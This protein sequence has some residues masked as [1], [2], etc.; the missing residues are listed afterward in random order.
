MTPGVSEG[1]A[2]SVIVFTIDAEGIPESSKTLVK[3]LM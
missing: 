2:R 3:R 1:S